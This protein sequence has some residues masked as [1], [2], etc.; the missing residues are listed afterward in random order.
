MTARRQW[1]IVLGVV[2]ALA[3][4]L[5]AATRFLGDEIIR[6]AVGEE[7][8]GFTAVTLD[9]PPRARTL[10]DYRGKVVLLNVW[11]TWCAPCRHE[12]PS[13]EAL[14]KDFAPR[15]FEIVAVSIDDEGSEAKV[16]EFLREFGITFDVL[17]DPHGTIQQIYQTTGVPENFLIGADGVIRKKAYAQDWNSEVNRTLVGRLL[18]EAGAPPA[19]SATPTPSTPTPPA[20]ADRM[21]VEVVPNPP[22]PAGR[23]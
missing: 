23:P 13:M 8:P 6:V 16:R 11:A 10:T 15:G 17:H 19:A 1:Q 3:L 20:G 22:A 5:W 14:Y 18:D 12:M 2:A 21:Q 7:A 9:T 4:G